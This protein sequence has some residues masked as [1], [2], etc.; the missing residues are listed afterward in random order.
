MTVQMALPTFV[1]GPQDKTATVDVYT[2]KSASVINTGKDS[3]AG[4]NFGGAGSILGGVSS[5][6]SKIPLTGG[7][8]AL[9]GGIASTI[10]DITSRVSS[11]P[12]SVLSKVMKAATPELTKYITSKI[13]SNPALN[14]VIATVGSVSRVIDPKNWTSAQAI[15]GS[16]NTLTGGKGT[17]ISFIDNGAA[18]SIVTAVA[19]KGIAAGIPGVIGQL[20]GANIP[21]VNWSNVTTSLLPDINKKGDIQSLKALTADDLGKLPTITSSAITDFSS[22]YP[23][24]DTPKSPAQYQSDYNDIKDTFGTINPNWLSAT[25]TTPEGVVDQAYN[26][27]AI[28][29]ASPEFQKTLTT[30]ALASSVSDDKL[31]LLCGTYAPA[32]KTA[33][34][35]YPA[36]FSTTAPASAAV[37]DPRSVT[38]TEQAKAA[39]ERVVTGQSKARQPMDIVT[40]ID[41]TDLRRSILINDIV[42]PLKEKAWALKAAG[43]LAWSLWDQDG[44]KETVRIENLY[45]PQINTLLIEYAASIRIYGEPFLI[46]RAKAG[47]VVL[48]TLGG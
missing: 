34:N 5:L 6:L 24:P 3:L 30:G 32:A 27:S 43:D 15:S 39:N 9:N 1:T 16:I 22:T 25:R 19:S 8:G 12:N 44:D 40:D 36:A 17:G 11:D 46:G 26:L 23:A 10:K 35:L 13:S 20:K 14:K 47:A 38:T 42:I 31:L 37:I 4:F 41:N 21:G 2:Q 48:P 33:E 7:L 29:N 28:T 45:R 18:T